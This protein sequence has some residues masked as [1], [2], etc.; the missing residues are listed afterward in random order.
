MFRIRS[1]PTTSP[2][3]SDGQHIKRP[4]RRRAPLPNPFGLKVYALR[5][6]GMTGGP[7]AY[8]ERKVH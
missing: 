2:V 4:A 1:K 8:S 5:L 7:P 6:P 3:H